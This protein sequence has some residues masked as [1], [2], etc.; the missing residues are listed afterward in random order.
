MIRINKWKKENQMYRIFGWE[1][2]LQLFIAVGIIVAL[3]LFLRKL[4]DKSRKIAQI[5]LVASIG[6]FVLLE[7]IGRIIM[8]SD[9]NFVEQ[10]PLN[11]FQVFSIISII[12]FF[13][14]KI[15]LQKFCYLIIVPVT[16]YGLLF[17]PEIYSLGSAFSL[18]L[19]SYILLSAV[20]IAN[21][22]LN[23]IWLD[24]DLE[25]KDIL[26]ASITFV[27]IVAFLHIFNII[28]R[29]TGWGIHANYFGTMG[30]S[31]DLV[32]GWIHSLM[33]VTETNVA[34]PLLCIL[35]LLAVL[36]GIQ[37]LLVLPFDLIKTKRLHQENIEELI[38]LGNMKKQQEARAKSRKAS[39]QILVRSE[40]KAKPKEHKN[41]TN[42]TTTGFVATNKEIKVNKDRKE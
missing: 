35:P 20:L 40:N 4:T 36:V 28:L 2:F 34:V 1:Y 25:K 5:V 29:F 38:A 32:I 15:S 21:G 22:I 30:D 19:I 14:K 37:F 8:I 9:F 17:V 10:L 24:E 3:I 41:V 33:P 7:Y 42:S 27:L 23:M 11:T 16:A 18:S 6:F 12:V 31:Y 26:D 39:S 13:I